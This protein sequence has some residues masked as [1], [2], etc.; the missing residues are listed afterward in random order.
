VLFVATLAA[1]GIAMSAAAHD[2]RPLSITAVEQARGVYRVVVRVPPT[3]EPGT[4]PQIVWPEDCEVREAATLVREFGGISLVACAD[5]LE[6]R[7]ITIDYP[8]YNPSLSSLVRVATATGLV[9][10]AVLAPD[11]LAWTVPEDPSWL[12]VARDYVVLGFKHIWEGPDH[13][14]FVAGLMLLARRPPRILLAVTGFTAAHSITLSLAALGLV[15]IPIAPVEAM[16]ALS[17]LFLAAEIARGDGASF[18]RRYPI[19]LSFTFGLLHGFGF[20][21]AL[22]EIGLPRGELAAGLVSFNLG[23]ELG[24]IAFVAAAGAVAFVGFRAQQRLASGMPLI[25]AVR[26]R[27]VTIGAY[28]L[29]V[30]AALWVLERSSAAFAG[31]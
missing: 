19:A 2:A 13:L 20:A 17:I 3:L 15:R 10:T 6:G 8:V 26:R 28:V 31:L 22:G 1:F 12:E 16:I 9:H 25:R 24:Q 29:G 5:G 18:S 23:V 4:A 27:A 30:P 7:T 14:M 11:V 21:S